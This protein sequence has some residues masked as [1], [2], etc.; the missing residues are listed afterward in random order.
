MPQARRFGARL[1]LAALILASA[2]C[3]NQQTRYASDDDDS[4]GMVSAREYGYVRP[5]SDV[6]VAGRKDRGQRRTEG[7][8]WSQ[9]R[10][11][12]KL[13][14]HADPRID[15]KIDGFRRD[16]QYLV[17]LSERARPYLAVVVGEIERRGLP[18]ELALLPHVESR[19]N[20]AAT[21]PVA[22]AGMW[23]FMPYTGR[24]MGLRQDAWQDERRDILASTRAAMDYLQQL[25]RRLGG[26]WELTMAAYNC[27]PGRVES[28][29]V[30][31]RLRGKPTDFWSLDLPAETE[32]YVPQILAAAR[33]V[34]APAN[35]GLRLPPVPSTP[36]LEVVRTDRPVDL[37]RVAQV[38]GVGIAELRKLN[39]GLKRGQT[40]PLGPSR[41][42]VPAGTGKRVSA[43][44]PQAQVLPA[45]ASSGG[46]ASLSRVAAAPVRSR[47]PEGPGVVYV[48]KSGESLASIARARGVGLRDLADANAMATYEALLPGQSLRIPGAGS[49]ADLV[50]HQVR[51]GDSLGAIAR[52]Y[53]VT[54]DDIRR[55]NPVSAQTL[56]NG[57]VLRI[58]RRGSEFAS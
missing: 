29:M 21:S 50:T 14:L 25:N 27:G 51:R 47:R 43:V 48:V 19:Y 2:G 41:L 56:R 46:A 35:Y 44:L 52:R 38:S 36:Q 16:P 31:N 15:R 17:K 5:A 55:W 11:G 39:A 40:T 13:D 26:D 9:V 6:V 33:L 58:Y 53:G 3:A 1:S 23:Q 32:N 30:A 7:D 54:V 49:S 18:A 34:A 57:V 12:M 45:T 4:G 28:A 22:A 10:A 20:P 37:E 24:E 42:V 8:L